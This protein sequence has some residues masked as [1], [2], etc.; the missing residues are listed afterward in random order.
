MARGGTRAKSG[1]KRLYKDPILVGVLC[2]RE[3]L[4]EILKI[5]GRK[6]VT[7]R[8][9]EALRKLLEDKNTNKFIK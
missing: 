3:E 4:I 5:H 8:L 9:K 2:E 7:E 1:R 6:A